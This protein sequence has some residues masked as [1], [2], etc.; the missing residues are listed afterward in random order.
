MNL[1][2]RAGSGGT[3]GYYGTAGA[4]K[5]ESAVSE[6][7]TLCL[8]V[9]NLLK[10]CYSSRWHLEMGRLGARARGPRASLAVCVR[11]FLCC[12]VER[13]TSR[14]VCPF[15]LKCISPTQ[16]FRPIAL[17]RVARVVTIECVAVVSGRGDGRRSRLSRG[18]P[19]GP[20]HTVIP[21]PSRR[22]MP[23]PSVQRPARHEV[24]RCPRSVGLESEPS[25]Q[26]AAVEAVD[27]RD[28][29]GRRTSLLAPQREQVGNPWSE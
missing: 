28:E 5:L 29:A 18:S 22:Q 3:R 4:T 16:L 19:S 21:L 2:R 20:T 13:A 17:V 7:L 12:G 26:L 15:L 25:K 11:A 14:C 9:K 1:H 24:R 6:T 27:A 10:C 23:Q 8:W